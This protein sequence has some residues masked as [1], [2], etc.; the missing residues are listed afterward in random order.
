MATSNDDALLRVQ[1]LH[2]EFKTRR[3]QALVLNGVD[4]EIRAGETLC[5][6]GESGCGKSMTALALLRL[7]PSPPGR[8]RD[9]RV[10]FQG[11]DLVQASDARMREVRGNRISMIFQEPMTSLN[12]VFTVG[13]QIGESLQ[14]HA[15]LN[16]REARQRAIEMLR[17][18]G[19]PAPERRVDEYPHQLSGGMRQRVMIAMALACRPDILIADEPTTALDV[20][21][22]A[23]IFDL[24]RELQREKGTAIMFI[25]H[26]MGAVAE[27]ADRVMVMYA[28][29]VI[30]QG[31]TEQVLSEPGHPYTRGLIDCLPEL[32]SSAA[33]EGDVHEDLAEIA[34]VVPSIW[35]LGTGCAFRER[36]PRAMERCAAEVP[37]MFAVTGEVAAGTPH[38]AACWL[39][40][41]AF[42]TLEAREREA[43]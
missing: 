31:T 40:G 1:D 11:E 19:I 6:V 32:G 22:Q 38:G 16:A 28:G 3:G 26:D 29:R 20:T 41:E 7:I 21:V 42:K 13:D 25:T 36:C 12:P 39:H 43:A 4:F 14:L 2:V 37:P 33:R 23:Q 15:G 5:V 24:L 9:G 10:L 8:I 17:Q 27:M 35:E 30:E 34:G 18:V